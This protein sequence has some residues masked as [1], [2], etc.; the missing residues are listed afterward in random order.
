MAAWLVDS[1]RGFLAWIGSSVFC[2]PAAVTWWACE[3]VGKELAGRRSWKQSK[4]GDLKWDNP[5]F[6]KI[7]LHS[8]W[9]LLS[10]IK[11]IWQILF[12]KQRIFSYQLSLLPSHHATILDSVAISVAISAF[13]HIDRQQ[14]CFPP[15]V[16]LRLSVSKLT[17]ADVWLCDGRKRNSVPY[18]LLGQDVKKIQLVNFYRGWGSDEW[19]LCS[20]SHSYTKYWV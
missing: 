15:L 19:M 6:R 4:A 16:C 7:M 11:W 14:Y 10:R 20:A 17:R 12:Q 1:F 18:A 3:Q 5:C 8:F 2:Q 9:D 13:L